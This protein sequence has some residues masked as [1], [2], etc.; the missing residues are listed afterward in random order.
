[1]SITKLKELRRSPQHYQYALANPKQSSALT[2]GIAS[3]VAV[4]EPERFAADFAV[5]DRATDAGAMA[6][7]RGQ[8]WD[9]FREANPGRTILTPA[10]FN[11]AHAISQAVRSDAIAMKYLASGDPEVTMLWD[12]GGRQCKGRAD[13][14]TTLEGKPWIVGVKTARDCRP[15]I[16][17]SQ[18]AKL[19]YHLQFAHYNDGYEA[20]TGNKAGM[21][22]IVVESAAPYAVAVYRITDDVL[23]QGRDEYL[24]LIETLQRCEASGEWPG[25]VPH[26]ED[27]TLPTWAYYNG[28]DDIEG[29]GLIANE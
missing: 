29:L 26:E 8:Y 15:M 17:G 10:E 4:L 9:A 16:F 23:A 19:G 22:E 7:R 25:P 27:L 20:I 1:M 28:D 6:P 5:W 11:L 2:L 13:W 21:V 14:L 24:Q 3:H 12:H 18:C